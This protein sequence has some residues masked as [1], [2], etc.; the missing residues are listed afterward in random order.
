[1]PTALTPRCLSLA[2]CPPPPSAPTAEPSRATQIHCI[3]LP[4]G[5]C[6]VPQV[7]WRRRVC[8]RPRQSSGVAEARSEQLSA[9]AGGSPT[10]APVAYCC[11]PLRVC[12]LWPLAFVDTSKSSPC[13]SFVECS[14]AELCLSHAHACVCR[15]LNGSRVFISSQLVSHQLSQHSIN[16]TTHV[17]SSAPTHPK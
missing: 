1:M 9:R 2:R 5:H 17:L 11:T 16:L 13:M 3:C 8:W 7:P 12:F 10:D 6:S 15:R 14:R 4:H